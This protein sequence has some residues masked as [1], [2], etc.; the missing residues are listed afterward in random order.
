MRGLGHQFL[1]PS[2]I[3]TY[4]AIRLWTIIAKSELRHFQLVRPYSTLQAN[5]SGFGRFKQ[6]QEWTAVMQE[7]TALIIPGRLTGGQ[8]PTLLA[9]LFAL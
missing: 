1:V 3:Y 4:A 9:R 5:G 2:E 8:I 7:T 6:R